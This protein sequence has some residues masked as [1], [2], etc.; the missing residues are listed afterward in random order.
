MNKKILFQKHE[1]IGTFYVTFFTT[2]IAFMYLTSGTK[3]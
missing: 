1:K 3:I 2:T